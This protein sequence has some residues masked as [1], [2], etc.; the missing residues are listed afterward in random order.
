MWNYETV[1]Q[2]NVGRR[3]EVK[4]L[5]HKEIVFGVFEYHVDGFLFQHDFSKL[6]D[7]DIL[8]L[9]IQLQRKHHH[10]QPQII[11]RQEIKKITYLQQSHDMRSG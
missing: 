4:L 2:I 1:R 3:E 11:R 10:H 9:S 6:D 7:I 5:T 8:N